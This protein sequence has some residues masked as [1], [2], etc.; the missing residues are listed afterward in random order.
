MVAFEGSPIYAERLQINEIFQ[1]LPQGP[2]LGLNFPPSNLPQ[3]PG[4]ASVSESVT[5]GYDNVYT[6]TEGIPDIL[7]LGNQANAYTYPIS[8]YASPIVNELLRRSYLW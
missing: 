1:H 5:R 2:A 3:A 4:F 6:P 7:F 8:I